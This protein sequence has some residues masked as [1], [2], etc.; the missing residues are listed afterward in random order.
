MKKNK[1]FVICFMLNSLI[2]F[3]QDFENEFIG[4]IQ[5]ENNE[6]MFFKINFSELDNGNIIGES[7]TDYYGENS[8]KSKI[9]GTIDLTK[10]RL[11]FNEISNITTVSVANENDF[12]YIK[13]TDLMI[14]MNDGKGIVKG[15]F[16]GYFNNGEECA[17]GQIY[18]VSTSFLNNIKALKGI[19]V[20]A[21]ASNIIANQQIPN[22]KQALDTKIE[23]ISDEVLS[24]AWNSNK[25]TLTVWDNYYEDQDKIDVYINNVLQFKAIEIKKEKQDLDFKFS[26][27]FCE[28]KI[29]AVNEGTK[30][31]NTVHAVLKDK[32]GFQP[33]VTKLRTGEEVRIELKR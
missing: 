3:G 17:T 27:D 29:V 1:L 10:K 24:I 8:T 2:N 15:D 18:M 25:G 22:I 21:L 32:K 16:N 14:K 28:I 23:M 13:A 4:T 6:T 26:G 5:T 7:I 9:E 31:P 12:C 11:S 20:D 19:D 33:L 30:P